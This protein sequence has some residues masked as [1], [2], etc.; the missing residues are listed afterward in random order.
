M[1]DPFPWVKIATE[2]CD[3]SQDPCNG[4]SNY[5]KNQ[6]VAIKNTDIDFIFDSTA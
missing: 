4:D 3:T 5:E 6:I 2:S 1:D